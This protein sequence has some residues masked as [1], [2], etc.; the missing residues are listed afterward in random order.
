MYDAHNEILETLF[1]APPYPSVERI[2]PV[3]VMHEDMICIQEE[4][5]TGAWRSDGAARG[6]SYPYIIRNYR[7]E[8]GLPFDAIKSAA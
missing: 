3:R 4:S 6:G 5:L 1:H 7:Q 8:S 2:R